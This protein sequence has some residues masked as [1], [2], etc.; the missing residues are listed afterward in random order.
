[1]IFPILLAYPAFYIS[2]LAL[3]S[4]WVAYKQR[5]VCGLFAGLASGVMHNAWAAGFLR[6]ML[7]RN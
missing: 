7:I 1:M 6:Q 5:S 2:V 4:I 3:A